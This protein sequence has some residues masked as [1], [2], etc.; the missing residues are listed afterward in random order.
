[1]ISRTLLATF[2]LAFFIP[3]P[4]F[5]QT[6][7]AVSGTVA[8][9][10]GAPISDATV[11]LT[12]AT[13][14]QT[15][16]DA[17]GA[18]SFA[19]VPAGLYVFS[20]RKAGYDTAT[21][22][23][24]V[25]L[26]GQ[27]QTASVRMH[28]AT[29]TTLRTIATVTANTRGSFNTTP[30]SVNVVTAQTFIDQSQPQ[31]TRVVSQIPG[32]QIS[33]PGNSANGAAA[34]SIVVPTIRGASSYETASLIDGH[35]LA[36]GS[37]GDYVTT[38]LQ[39]YLLG[40][41]ETIKGPGADAPEVNNA[42]GGTLN[43]RTKD[44]TLT[45]TPTVLVG[46]DNHGGTFSNFGVSDTIANNRLGFVAQIATQDSPS[47]LNGTQVLF[48]PSFGY[49][50]GNSIAGNNTTGTL[51]NT[52]STNTTSYSLL[53]CC[54]S[55]L[56]DLE[57]TGELLKA[58]YKFSSATTATVSYLGSQSFTD[59]VGNTGNL[60]LATFAPGDPAYNG[61]LKANSPVAVD[62]LFAGQP[63]REINNEPI[64]QGEVSSTLGND[65]VLG[66]YYH[67]SITRLQAQGS[68]PG[69][70]DYNNVT[71]FGTS[72]GTP[73]FNGLSTPVGFQDF[74]RENEY[75]KLTGYTFEYTHPFGNDNDVS[76]SV[77]STN[78][79]SETYTQSPS[80][81]NLGPT[82]TAANHVSIPG[83]SSQVFTTYLLRSHFYLGPK[84]NVTLA[85]YL[86]TY[87]NT[88]AQSCP[89]DSFGNYNCAFDG[90]N[91][92]FGT[93]NTTHD[94]PRIGLVYQP[95]SNIAI[96]FS[97]GSAI[98]P[99]YLGLLSNV[100]GGAIS[101]D[102]SNNIVTVQTPNS[103]I[104]PETA[105]GYDLGADYRF[106]DGVTSLSTD[107][108]ETNL[109][110]HF[111]GQTIPTGLS[112][113]APLDCGGLAPPGTPIYTQTPINISNSR[114]EGFEL[115]VRRQP[116]FGWG[117]VVEG[118]LQRGYV[119]NL[120]PNFYCSAPN[121]V[122]T[123]C[124]P[125]N[126]NQNLNIVANE[127][128]NGEGVGFSSTI[129]SLNTRLPYFQGN[130]QASYTFRNGAY[131]LFGDTLYGKNNSLN[132][133]PFGLA[134]ASLRY[135]VAPNLAFQISGD[136]IF[137][138]YRGLIPVFGGGVAIP[139]ANGQTAAT[140]ANV[141]GPATYRFSLIEQLP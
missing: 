111:F 81:F 119:Y 33:F 85:N 134:Y 98:A 29:L 9:D 56:G 133:P 79:Q 124:I 48:D 8:D 16:T 7:T 110:N 109:F 1:M 86:N 45:P 17:S 141:L 68:S 87:R 15:T 55:V 76:F 35:P 140:T 115:S 67:A 61:S 132:E 93:T 66:R 27:T 77:D 54:F 88:F 18:F 50:N 139:L 73:T 37:F 6:A 138:A 96:R 78:S 91:V 3:G 71:L 62:F 43:F 127:N 40:S 120:P 121:T 135:P 117:F 97:A 118:S 123:P 95:K 2:L 100:P 30:A 41:V 47:A 80:S 36:T 4:L 23:E 125:A 64:F 58:R 102:S 63:T 57:T 28:A 10:T 49:V 52:A 19:N 113:G 82:T 46:V 34:G 84:L 20:A 32:V 94:D 12:G 72:S 130:A 26:A 122:A 129:G 128:L 21:Q 75:D 114:F 25:V 104:K 60:T 105:F 83:G 39:S 5:A 24:F 131:V 101:F 136:N 42:I 89:L 99:P 65:T 11:T 106:K 90:S 51:G 137:N 44:P 31:V 53:A 69:G 38:F 116:Q 70:L 92:T 13:R 112:C 59:Q 107:V 108:Y 74:F 103:S 14:L 126:Y 22:S